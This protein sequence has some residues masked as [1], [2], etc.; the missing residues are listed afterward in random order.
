MFHFVDIDRDQLFQLIS[1]FWKNED[2][3]HMMINIKSQGLT[4]KR[5]YQHRSKPMVIRK[6]SI[7]EFF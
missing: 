4:S 7:N 2:Y 1:S 3:I 5:F 6:K